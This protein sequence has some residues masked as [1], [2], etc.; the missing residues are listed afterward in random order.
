MMYL[1]KIEDDFYSFFFSLILLG[2]IFLGMK[3]I[4][5]HATCYLGSVVEKWKVVAL[6]LGDKERERV[7]VCVYVCVTFVVI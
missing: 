6:S 3:T 2:F 7:C 1:D 5:G 4:K